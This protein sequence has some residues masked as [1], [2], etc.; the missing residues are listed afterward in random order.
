M[1][2][3]TINIDGAKLRA[4]LEST[5]GKSIYKIALENGYSDNL[6]ATAIRKGQ[7][8]AVVQNLAKTYGIS[9]EAYEIKEPEPERPINEPQQLSLLDYTYPN[10]DELKAIVK[11]ATIEALQSF[12]YIRVAGVSYDPENKRFKLFVN[13]EDLR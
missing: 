2:K 7:A 3:T 4:L 8:S 13:E 6:I 11:E 12:N 9:R 5:T 1:S 10:R